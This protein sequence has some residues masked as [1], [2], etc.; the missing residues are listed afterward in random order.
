MTRLRVGS[1]T[2][3]LDDSTAAGTAAATDA[4]AGLGGAPAG[5]VVVYASI[6]YDLPE[7]LRAIRAVT[8]DAP[9]IG[10]TSSGH[11]AGD[12]FLPSGTGVEVL[13]LGAGQYRFGVASVSGLRTDPSTAGRDLARAALDAAGPDR[14]PHAA[15]LVLADG[16][17]RNMQDLLTGIYRVTGATVPVVGG[18]AGADHT[19]GVTHVFHDDEVLT[20][21]AVAVW[22]GAERPLRVVLGHGWEALTLPQLITSV[23]GD[24][25]H[26]IAGRPAI[27]VVREAARPDTADRPGVPVPDDGPNSEWDPDSHWKYSIGLIE[28]DGTRFIRFATF[29]DD[30]TLSTRTPLPMFGAV[31]VMTATRDALLDVT[32]HVVA[33]ALAGAPDPAVMLTFSCVARLDMLGDRAAEES[34]RLHKAAAP[35]TT[36]GFYTYGEFARTAGVSGYH[37]ATITA[38]AL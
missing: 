10:A 37:N 1:A 4:M 38:L 18:A 31:Q 34:Q 36:F 16:L 28:P 2:S 19:L 13:V 8:G 14:A 17:G 29:E 33:D 35:V 23:D 7:L 22:I 24:V 32:E 6:R 11:F 3:R 15:L 26:E 30:G 12:E 20:Q 25:V 27:D 5:L 21:G 9:L